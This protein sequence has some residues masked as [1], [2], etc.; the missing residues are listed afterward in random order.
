V[1]ERY[2]KVTIGYH[3]GRNE[4]HHADQESL[5]GNLPAVVAG[6]R[7]RESLR[8]AQGV[9]MYLTPWGSSHPSW[10]VHPVRDQ[11]YDDLLTTLSRVAEKTLASQAGLRAL[12][13]AGAR[14]AAVRSR[15]SAGRGSRG[16]LTPWGP[17]PAV[18]RAS[19]YQLSLGNCYIYMY[20]VWTPLTLGP[21]ADPRYEH[22]IVG[23]EASQQPRGRSHFRAGR[24]FW[25]RDYQ[26][27]S[28]VDRIAGK[29][30]CG[31]WLQP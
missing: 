31:P 21:A 14:P 26:Y 5:G 7:A 29:C 16:L 22:Q 8:G 15:G 9:Y 18:L 30:R 12:G 3:P 1:V 24:S 13:R 17:H 6:R 27:T 11:Y 25:I 28:K 23:L 20:S 2:C 4:D 19:L 10:D